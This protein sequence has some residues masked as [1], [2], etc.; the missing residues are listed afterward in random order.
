MAEAG[1]QLQE[2]LSGSR[3]PSPVIPNMATEE[4]K[5]PTVVAFGNVH[6]AGPFSIAVTGATVEPATVQNIIRNKE[7]RSEDDC[8]LIS[9]DIVNTDERK[10]LNFTPSPSSTFALSD[11]VGNRIRGVTF[12]YTSRIVGS[13][14][15]NDDI[16]PGESRTHREAFTVPPPKTEQLN[17][18]VDLSAFRVSETVV[19]EIPVATIDGF[20]R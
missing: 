11:D 18:T 14:E 20:P 6:A 16:L 15:P 7:S 2:S 17:L 9:F 13:I 12:G 5:E 3:N 8:L 4:P 10:V 19:F 1:R